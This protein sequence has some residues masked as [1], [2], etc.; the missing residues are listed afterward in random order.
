MKRKTW[1]KYHKWLGIF[2][3]FFLVMFC[4]SGIVLNHRRFFAD[5]NVS[6]SLLPD[7]YAFK[8]WNN[9]LLRGTLRCKDDQGRGAVLIYGAAGIIRTDTTASHFAEYNKG[10]PAGAD[11]RQIRGVVQTRQ[12]KLFAA[13]TMGLYRLDPHTGWQSVPLPQ[14][15]GNEL[16]TDIT[17]RG[18]TLIVLGRSCL[19]IS[20]PPYK[21]FACLQLQAPEGYEGKTT[22]FRQMWMLHSGALFGAAGK[23]IVDGIALILIVLC[24]TGVWFWLRPRNTKVLHWHNKTGITTLVLTIFI[25]FTGWALRPPVMIALA[26]HSIRPLPGTTLDNDNPWYDRLRMIRYDEQ[27]HEWLLST[28]EGF[29]SLRSFNSRPEHIIATPPVSVMGQTVWQRNAQGEWIIGSFDGLYRWDRQ[30]GKVALYDGTAFSNPT[31]P[32]TSPVG[33]TISGYSS[34]FKGRDC[35]VDYFSGTDFAVQPSTFRHLPISLW[36]LALEIHTGRI[37][38][39]AIGSFVFIFIVGLSV[40]VVLWSGKKI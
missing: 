1:R 11:Y 35:Q 24:V 16:L 22:L 29:F 2:T 12:G 6:R 38:L 26:T 40:I 33:Q 17:T 4:L 32:G 13:S 34:D 28:S 31:I 27:E 37:Y 14:T 18:D 36:N 3:S 25:T 39:G 9:G 20:R 19:Y 10:L 21:Q 15:D 30:T 23:L 7:R 8:Q 5:V